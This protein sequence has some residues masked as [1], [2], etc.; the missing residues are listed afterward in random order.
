ML[1]VLSLHIQNTCE[2]DSLYSIRISITLASTKRET[3][4]LYLGFLRPF[5]GMKVHKN[6]KINVS[7]V[8]EMTFWSEE[9]CR[10]FELGNIFNFNSRRD[11]LN[12]LC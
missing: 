11:L 8:I 5:D 4:I 1:K 3:C 9:E 7:L 6:F 2:L 10:N 12:D